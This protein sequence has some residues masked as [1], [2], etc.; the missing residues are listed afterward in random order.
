MRDVSYLKGTSQ[1]ILARWFDEGLNALAETCPTGRT[2]YD[3][4]SD[5]LIE[6]LASGNT[7]PLDDVIEESAKL[8]QSLKPEL[9]L[10]VRRP[11]P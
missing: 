1:A 5:V 8:N 10:D 3:K 7:E 6:M 11:S 2:V 4:Y 9:S